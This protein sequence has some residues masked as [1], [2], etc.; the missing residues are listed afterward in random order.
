MAEVGCGR[1]VQTGEGLGLTIH[2]T[3][4]QAAFP[5]AL[6]PGTVFETVEFQIPTVQLMNEYL[7]F[8]GNVTIMPTMRIPPIKW[9]I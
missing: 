4:V 8:L 3:L 5:G 1:G 7:P 2:Y 6:P 9:E